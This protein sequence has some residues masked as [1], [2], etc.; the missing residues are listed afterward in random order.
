MSA[1]ALESRHGEF[2][3]A[4]ASRFRTHVSAFVFSCV[5]LFLLPAAYLV[6]IYRVA[7]AD[8]PLEQLRH[9]FLNWTCNLVVFAT[10]WR[11]TGPLPARFAKAIYS[12]VLAHGVLAFLVLAGRDF[13]SR[14]NLTI[15]AGVS[16]VIACAVVW[17]RG[18]LR[19]HRV[20]VIGPGASELGTW[21]HG[22]A[23]VVNRADADLRGYDVVVVDVSR[24]LPAEWTSAVAR[25]M[26][27]GCEVRHVAEYLEERRG[28]VSV[29]HFQVDHVCDR[30]PVY[31]LGK[32]LLDISVAVF[33]LPVVVPIVGVAMLGSLLVLGRPIFFVQDRIGLGGIP[34]RMWKLRTMRTPKPG[35]VYGETVPGDDRVPPY[36]RLMRR[37]RIDELP[38]LWNVLLGEMSLIGPRPEAAN[39][40]AAYL[41]Q[42]PEYAYRNL[43]R[44]GITGWAQVCTGPSANVHEA[45][46]KLAYDLYYVKKVSLLL[47]MQIVA[48]TI[49]T[50][51]AGSGVR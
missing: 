15:A 37:L 11:V 48:R 29:E 1:Q 41:Q 16:V 22:I 14:P 23:E 42:L 26:L 20:A 21:I 19:G 18:Q 6:G 24:E 9:L 46:E 28:R 44:P 32:R 36:G 12:L 25:A 47:D 43:V 50:L 39:F 40:H 33:F 17:L 13:F 45:R 5:L 34:F 38:Q 10:A 30:S 31:G 51:A 3:G 4:A 8:I 7:L 2:E 49:W 27:A 35:E